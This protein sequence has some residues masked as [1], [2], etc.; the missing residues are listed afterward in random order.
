MVLPR[1]LI[2][3]WIFLSHS[4]EKFRRGTLSCF[5]NFE[6]R[7]MLGINRK[8]FWQGSDSNPEPT[9]WEPFCP[10]PTV[11][12]YLWIKRVGNFGLKKK[13][14][15]TPLNELF[16]LYIT[17]TAKNN[18][19]SASIASA[20]WWT[21]K[22]LFFLAVYSSHFFRVSF[23]FRDFVYAVLLSIRKTFKSPCLPFRNCSHVEVYFTD[24]NRGL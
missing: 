16:F 11:V 6:Y 19:Q 7:N 10:K 20:L 8:N 4:A 22:C 24:W 14:K 18:K 1:F 12:I 15:T 13:R 21:G 5:T 3:C 17:Y 2:F 23:S 9:A